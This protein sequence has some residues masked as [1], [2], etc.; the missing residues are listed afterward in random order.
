MR[1]KLLS[2]KA[3]DLILFKPALYFHTLRYLKLGQIYWR[4]WYRFSR[5]CV[6]PSPRPAVRPVSGHWVPPARRRQSLEDCDKF[7]FLNETG[8]LSELGWDGPQREKL[9]RYNQHYF[10]DLNSVDAEARSEWHLALVKRWIKENTPGQGTGWEPYPTSLRIVNWIKWYLG[11]HSLHDECLQSLAIQTR[12]LS[13]RIEWH[14]LGNHLLAN[15]KAMVF[16]GLCFKGS[17]AQKWLDI[18]LDIIAKELPEQ[19][20]PDGGNFERS[21]MYHAIFLEDILDLINLAGAYPGVVG[22]EQVREW[23]ATAR[24]M[25]RWLEGMC[26]PDGE[27]AFFNDAAIGIAPSPEK[28][29]TYANC[30]GISINHVD[31]LSGSITI[32]RFADSGYIRLDAMNACAFLDVAPIGPDYLPGHAHADTL[33]FELSLY[34]ERVLVNGGTSQYGNELVRLEERGTAAHNTVVVNN[35][36]SS[37]VWS[38]FRVARRAYP[39]GIEIA[40]G[41][42]TALVTCEHDGFM[43]LPGRPVHKRSWQ[44]F[45][46]KLVVKDRIEGDFKSGIA[47]FHFHPDLYVNSI[48]RYRY[49]L[50]LPNSRQDIQIF[51]LHGV[52]CIEQ[53]FF[54]PEFGIRLNSQCLAIHFESNNNI[55]VEIS[56][57]INE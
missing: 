53:S 42:E 55:A 29:K 24:K 48:D 57:S 25:L 39:L 14:L 26:H 15:A 30:L 19:V 52:A 47:R 45:P 4:I 20:L 27:I 17:E 46:G 3:L 50:R 23:R 21:P 22:K 11:G 10:D 35:E 44:F 16:A 40:Q 43:R 18:G 36:N 13:R 12:W 8:H 28:I 51:V 2:K 5:P 1:S 31:T 32:S 37:E 6:D 56:W 7:S 38:G 33:S 9:W 49:L 41:D 34:G 54:A